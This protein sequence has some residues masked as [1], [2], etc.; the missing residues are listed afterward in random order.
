V[1][2]WVAG[3]SGEIVTPFT[4]ASRA[5]RTSAMARSGTVSGMNVAGKRRGSS[6]QNSTM[7]RVSARDA[8]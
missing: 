6:E 8:A 2:E 1:I 5:N 7:P 3:G 4:P